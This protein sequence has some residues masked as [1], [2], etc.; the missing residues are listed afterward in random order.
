MAGRPKRRAARAAAAGLPPPQGW[1][2]QD[3]A[4]AAS[5]DKPHRPGTFVKGRSGHP[6]GTTREILD[7][8]FTAKRLAAIHR[9][10]AIETL[11][12]E[13]ATPGA[14]SVQAAAILLAYSD[15]RPM[16]NLQVRTIKD[17]SDLSDEER[18]ALKASLKAKL[19]AE[20]QFRV[21]DGRLIDVDGEDRGEA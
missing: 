20:G 2:K 3:A 15:G 11:V 21:L 17:F 12:R 7:A 9:P 5:E 1:K 19:I 18:A 14:T 4:A 13:L 16:Q 6:E 8:T 10:A